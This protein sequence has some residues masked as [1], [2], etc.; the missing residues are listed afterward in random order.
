[1]IHIA[2]VEDDPD[3]VRMLRV[4]LE[5]FER[6]TT[7]RFSIAE[8]ADGLDFIGD[9]RSK[10]DLVLMDIDMPHLNG[11]AAAKKLRRVDENAVILFVTNMAQYAIRGYEVDALDFLVKPITKYHLFSKLRKALRK[12]KNTQ[13]KKLFLYSEDTVRCVSVHDIRYIEVRE[14]LLTY[15]LVGEDITVRGQ[16]DKLETELEGCHFY[17]IYKSYLVNLDYVVGVGANTV[18][19][20]EENLCLSRARKKHFMQTLADYLGSAI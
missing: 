7:E 12:I 15:H 3:C 6:E 9:Y 1:M 19:V 14:H 8:F 17:R 18:R 16:M 13:N 2:I 5:E 11:I 4:Y 20:G 10:Y